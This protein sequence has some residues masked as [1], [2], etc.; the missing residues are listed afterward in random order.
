VSAVSRVLDRIEVTFDVETLVADAG[1]IV[2]G[3]RRTGGSVVGLRVLWPVTV[4]L[5]TS[6]TWA[7]RKW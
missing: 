2:P 4:R 3:T 1:L 5:M 7:R 6:R